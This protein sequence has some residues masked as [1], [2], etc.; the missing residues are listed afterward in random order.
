MED[1]LRPGINTVASQTC[2]R[3][4]S[5]QRRP[6]IFEQSP[7]LILIYAIG[8]DLALVGADRTAQLG[9]KENPH[10]PIMAKRT[11]AGN[12]SALHPSGAADNFP[13]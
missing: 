4:M 1:V 12:Q 10:A 7:Q 11:S 3:T 13:R 6:T 2:R 5:R 9:K 8:L